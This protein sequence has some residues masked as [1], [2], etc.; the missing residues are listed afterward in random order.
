MV[1]KGPSGFLAGRGDA[2]RWW[3]DFGSFRP[4][5]RIPD[6]QT[7]EFRTSNF[8]AQPT[9]SETPIPEIVLTDG[10][11]ASLAEQQIC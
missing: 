1:Q 9:E 4:Y 8:G 2:H 10:N 3:N 6:I 5:G 11:R 7:A